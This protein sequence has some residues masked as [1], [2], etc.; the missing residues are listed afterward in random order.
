MVHL[1]NGSTAVRVRSSEDCTVLDC[2]CAH[3]AVLWTQMCLA[4]WSAWSELHATARMAHVATLQER[5]P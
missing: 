2:G 3:S 1:I 5:L 4:H